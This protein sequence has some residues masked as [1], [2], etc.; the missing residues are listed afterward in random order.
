M[1]T[2]HKHAAIIK[3][4]ADGAQIQFKWDAHTRFPDA[5]S[6]VKQPTWRSD[7]DYRV[8]PEVKPDVV[9]TFYVNWFD[10][11]VFR[12]QYGSRPVNLRL[13]F[14]GDTMK[15]KKAEVI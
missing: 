1:T 12:S 11:W 3:Q 8:K 10:N 13:T 5:W 15:L 14:D 4:W 2:P 6:D 9:R 7:C